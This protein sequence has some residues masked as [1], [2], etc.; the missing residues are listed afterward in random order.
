MSFSKIATVVLLF[1]AMVMQ[2]QKYELGKVSKKELEEK[3]YPT[4]TSAAAAILF[5]KAKTIY[6][7]EKQGFYL[8]HIYE[9]RIKIYNKEGLKWAN[10]KVPYRINY[11]GIIDDALSFSE[12]VTYNLVNNEIVKTKLKSEGS[13]RAN[14]N[15]YWDQAS[16]TLP[17]VVVGSI[18]EF[19]YTMRSEN[20]VKF[21]LFNFQYNIPVKYA[22][23]KTE[24][25][26][27]F[28]YNPIFSGFHKVNSDVQVD[29]GYQ[30]YA[31]ENN[32]GRH[33]SYKQINSIH[34]AENIPAL[35]EED[36]M[37]N[38]DNYKTSVD[39]ELEKTRFPEVPEKI[40]TQ[41]WE[42]VARVIYKDKSFGHQLSLKDYFIQDL[43]MV[44]KNND[45]TEM[46]KVKAVFKFVQ[47]KMN[48]NGTY[49]Y[50]T[51][52]G[53]EKAYAE[54]IGNIADINFILISML[55]YAGLNANP[56]L[57]STIDHGIPVFPNRTV[58]NYVIA[59]VDMDGKRVL[60]D[61]TS[62]FTSP[63]ILRFSTLNWTGRLIRGDQSSQEVNL[64]PLLVSKVNNNIMAT[65]DDTG[66]VT[67]KIRTQT[68]DYLAMQFRQKYGNVTNENYL[69]ILEE[70]WNDIQLQGYTVA[71]KSTDFTKP[72]VE[73]YNLASDNLVA[74]SENQMEINPLLFFAIKKNPF[75]QDKRVLPI[76][77]GF[78]K[79]FKYN[80]SI[81]FPNGYKI[82]SLP[83]SITIA[84]P[85][86]VQLFTYKIIAQDNK[87]QLVAT[88]EN[89]GTLLPADFY[90]DL[91]EFYKKVI[92][93][94][95][96]K[97]ILK[98]I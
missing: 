2:A 26:E 36:F 24:V 77:F 76:Y 23:Y 94:Q 58:F 4:D 78:P 30:N 16:V 87:I 79:H 83:K 13:F 35:K 70:E 38:L 66:K 43:K 6:I 21:P 22:E 18:I 46:T 50:L 64:T 86:N 25:P 72:I 51:D 40:F 71:N 63:D 93:K 39:Y 42:D 17:N 53:V 41:T 55:N 92:E 73:S 28:I 33:M 56:V 97:I 27:F 20:M 7:Y 9:F 52:K 61:A 3:V 95:Q 90:E 31:D 5:T 54:R 68:S 19:K 85:E 59:A 37:D 10:F 34:Q 65:I 74:V 29:F 69:D 49:G 47:N 15:E 67:A 44:L 84:T 89:N 60:L 91:K 11:E 62:K 45:S 32:Q 48:W 8:N 14:L 80:I 96:E 88:I 81:D 75:Q 12:A 82:E 57:V 1:G 98:K